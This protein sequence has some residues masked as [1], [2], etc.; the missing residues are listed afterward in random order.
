[1]DLDPDDRETGDV[2]F[3]SQA[4]VENES[5]TG[6]EMVNFTYRSTPAPHLISLQDDSQFM[7]PDD[8]ET[9]DVA[10]ASQTDASDGRTSKTEL[11][12]F[13]HFSTLLCFTL[14]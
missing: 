10:S 7:D 9:E 5:D 11:V 6:S 3:M 8:T 2:F 1:M 12:S 4:D 13:I 14:A